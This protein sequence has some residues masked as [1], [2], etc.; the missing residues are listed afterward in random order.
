MEAE[1]DLAIVYDRARR[2]LATNLSSSSLHEDNMLNV[3]HADSYVRSVTPSDCVGSPKS[4]VSG[5]TERSQKSFADRDAKYL[6]T[7]QPHA[8]L[9]PPNVLESKLM[10]GGDRGE[11]VYPSDQNEDAVY[12]GG[13]DDESERR[14]SAAYAI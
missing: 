2:L 12:H 4:Q 11:D 10:V 13:D 1:E 3:Y 7:M 6:G 14:S 9:F 5:L 8:S